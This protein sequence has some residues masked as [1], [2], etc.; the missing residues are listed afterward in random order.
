[1]ECGECVEKYPQQIDIP[2]VLMDVVADLEDD[3]F[4][5]RLAMA[6]KMLNMA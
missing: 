4:H 3:Q 5:E 6:K 1:M 2:T